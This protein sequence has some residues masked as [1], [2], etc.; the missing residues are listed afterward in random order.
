[1]STPAAAA[2]VTHGIDGVGQIETRGIDCI[3][4]A[5]SSPIVALLLA[6]GLY[7]LLWYTTEPYRTP[8]NRP[9]DADTD[10]EADPDFDD[11]VDLEAEALLEEV[12]A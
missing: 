12:T 11:R 2:A 9:V 1:M 10:A 3:P 5:D 7:A 6:G 4:P 8:A